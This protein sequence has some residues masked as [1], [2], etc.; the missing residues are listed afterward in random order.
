[1]TVVHPH[2]QLARAVAGASKPGTPIRHARGVVIS[3]TIGQSVV[4]LDGGATNVTAF[5]YGHVAS[6]PAGTVVDALVVGHK[7]YVIGAYGTPQATFRARVH[8][9][10]AWTTVNGSGIFGYDT[11]DTDPSGS[12]NTGTGQ[13]TC[14]VPGLYRVYA[15]VWFSP[16]AAGQRE[17]ASIFHGATETTAGSFPVAQAAGAIVLSSVYDEIQCAAADTLQ[18]DHSENVAG[19]AGGTSGVSAYALFSYLHP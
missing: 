18:I 11:I 19:V 16:T 10:G 17:Q 6:L 7:T 5:N 12:Y 15:Q 2:R 3:S 4:T 13:F 1:M 14:P 8:R 9:S